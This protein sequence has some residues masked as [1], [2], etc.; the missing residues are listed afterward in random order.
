MVKRAGG[1]LLLSITI[2]PD[3]PRP[4]STQ[5]Y[6]ALRDLILAGGFAVGERLPASRTLA[7]ELG[8]SRTTVIDAFD[9]LTAEGLIESRVGAGAYVSQALQGERPRAAE[10]ARRA[11]HGRRSCRGRWRRRWA[12]SPRARG[13][14]RRHARSPPRCRHSRPS[15]WRSGH[16]W[17]PGTGAARAPT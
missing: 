8:L 13:C 14:R 1:A 5:L 16:A 7:L 6:V 10:R 4:V 2:D 9:R 12:D 11:R 17:R 15:R 3:S